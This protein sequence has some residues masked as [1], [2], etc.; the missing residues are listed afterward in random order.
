MFLAFRPRG[1]ELLVVL[2]NAAD[3]ANRGGAA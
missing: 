2:A 3:R 1:A